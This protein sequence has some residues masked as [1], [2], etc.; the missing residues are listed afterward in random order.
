[1]SINQCDQKIESKVANLSCLKGSISS[2][3][4]NSNIFQSSPKIYQIVGQLLNEIPF[5]IAQSGHTS[6]NLKHEMVEK[7]GVTQASKI[8]FLKIC[9][10]LKNSK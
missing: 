2:F 10:K 8:V 4:L 5:K 9:T 3:H 6:I 1:M 7:I